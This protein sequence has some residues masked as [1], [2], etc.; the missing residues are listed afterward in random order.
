MAPNAAS[1]SVA[2][3]TVRRNVR[4]R[5]NHRP[6]MTSPSLNVVLIGPP[7]AGKGTQAA[8]LGR[9]LGVATISTGEMLRRAAQ[10]GAAIGL[11]VKAVMDRGELVDDATMTAI[12]AERLREADTQTGFVMDGFPRT[13]E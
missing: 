2:V 13:V 1:P 6:G 5:D 4:R 7:G 11:A 8:R 12:V 3:R 9:A 10:S